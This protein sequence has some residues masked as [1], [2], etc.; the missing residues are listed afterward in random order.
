MAMGNSREL[1]RLEAAAA[2][3]GFALACAHQSAEEFH[4]ALV[5]RYLSLNNRWHR[6]ASVAAVALLAALLVII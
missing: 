5:R 4:R 2:Y 6:Y 3:A 1:A